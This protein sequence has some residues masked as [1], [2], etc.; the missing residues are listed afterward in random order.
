MSTYEAKASSQPVVATEPMGCALTRYVVVDLQHLDM[1]ELHVESDKQL[2]DVAR[3]WQKLGLDDVTVILDGGKKGDAAGEFTISQK[4][5]KVIN[6]INAAVTGGAKSFK[7]KPCTV[8]SEACT[9]IVIT[10]GG[11]IQD[12]AFIKANG[13]TQADVVLKAGETWNWSTNTVATKMAF[14]V[15]ATATGVNSIINKGTLVSDATAM[16]AIYD[17]TT[18][19]PAQVTTIPFVNDGTWNISGAI[20]NVQFDVTNNGTVNIAK[21]AQYRQDG[22]T[23]VFTNEATTLPKRFGVASEKIGKVNNSGVFAT[24]NDGKINNYGLIEHDD[25]DAKTYITANQSLNADGFTADADFAANFNAATS[26][27]GNK[28]GRINL[29][30]TNKDEDNVSVSAAL[31]QGFVSVTVNGEVT[32]ALDASVVG[33]KVNYI[34]INK[35]ITEIKAVSEQVKYLEINQP[36]TEIVWN[37]PTTTVYEGLIVLSDVNIKLGTKIVATTTYIGADMYVGGKFNKAAIAAE[38]TDPA[39]APTDWDG[40]YGNTTTNVATKYIT[41]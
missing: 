37:V 22:G 20:L 5:I 32:G 24:V 29:P 4:T 40:Y 31:A 21:G 9:E 8:A 27:A 15:D 25:P 41:Y 23:N 39:Y 3:V 38:G 10:G 33:D 1:S 6:D 18:P 14:K 19:T 13:V 2:R 34:I 12:L 17:N 30:Y 28:M 26:G 7:V 35:G 36:G 11:A 16:I